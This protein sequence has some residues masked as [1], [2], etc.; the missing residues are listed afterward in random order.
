MIMELP[1]IDVPII[2]LKLPSTGKTI[3]ARPFLVKEEKLLLMAAQSKD[4]REIINATKQVINNCLIDKID[5]ETL[6]FFD[7]DYLFIALRAKSVGEIVE[8]NFSCNNLV[9]GEKCGGVFP[10]ALDISNVTIE[11]SDIPDK[12]QVSNNM[13]VKLKYPTYTEMKLANAANPLQAKLDL[14]SSCID[15]LYDDQSVYSSKDMQMQQI[16][17]FIES[18]TQAQFR[19]IENWI[20][21]MPTFVLET[22]QVCP[23]CGFNHKIRYKDFT[24]F[25]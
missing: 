20:D 1:K 4:S 10:V 13:G 14:A 19:E 8:V 2:E 17:Q 5:V 21:N 16:E 18:L 6:P 24:S 3:K 7:I 22:E 12:F 25:F 11:K 15:Y 23:K 9:N